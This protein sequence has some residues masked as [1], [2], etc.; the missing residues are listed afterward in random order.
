M[1]LIYAHP[2]VFGDCDPA[3]IVYYP[4]MFSWMDAGFHRLLYPHGGHQALCKNLG[5]IG[6]GLVSAS[7]RFAKPVRDM[8]EIEIHLDDMKWSDKSLT[9][10]YAGRINGEDHFTGQEV[11]CLFLASDHGIVAGR[12]LPLRRLLE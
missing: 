5:A 10:T 11:R 7:A 12:I 1:S 3:G 2:V 6:I 9:L 4:Q 8:D